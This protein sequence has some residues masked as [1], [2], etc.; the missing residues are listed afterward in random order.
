MFSHYVG[1][2]SQTSYDRIKSNLWRIWFIT[3]M[4]LTINTI[5]DDLVVLFYDVIFFF[6]TNFHANSS[7]LANCDEYENFVIENIYSVTTATSVTRKSSQMITSLL[8]KHIAGTIIST[9][10]NCQTSDNVEY[11]LGYLLHCCFTFLYLLIYI[12]YDWKQT[13]IRKSREI[14]YNLVRV[15]YFNMIPRGAKQHL[16]VKY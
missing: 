12:W 14:S 9:T 2:T 6:V 11:S 3:T 8:V 16:N 4:Q 13:H 15:L 10:Q 7:S 1:E 5:N